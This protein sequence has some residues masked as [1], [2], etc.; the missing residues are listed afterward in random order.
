[1]LY[2]KKSGFASGFHKDP[3][4]GTGSKLDTN[5]VDIQERLWRYSADWPGISGE[6][7]DDPAGRIHHMDVIPRRLKH[8]NMPSSGG[9]FSCL[10]QR[11]RSTL[12]GK[13][14][15]D[16]IVRRLEHGPK[17]VSVS[18]LKAAFGAAELFLREEE[19]D[20]IVERFAD[21]R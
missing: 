11:A 20:C 18:A 8:P 21:N 10:Q 9:V 16:V 14:R 19:T 6:T 4:P 17:F 7:D 3:D 13:H 5:M 12:V 2:E 15:P 1:M